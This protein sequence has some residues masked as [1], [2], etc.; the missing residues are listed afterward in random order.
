MSKI[1]AV[2]NFGSGYLIERRVLNATSGIAV[3]LRVWREQL[4]ESD[5]A[6]QT[7]PD[8]WTSQCVLWRRGSW[9]CV[10]RSLHNITWLF[11]RVHRTL[12][13]TN[14]QHKCS[15]IHSCATDIWEFSSI[16][17]IK[18]HCDFG[19]LQNKKYCCKWLM[20]QVHQV[21]I[22]CDSLPQVLPRV[23]AAST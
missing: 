4:P 12:D 7:I 1:H 5:R 8:F 14:Y 18:W 20:L 16:L 17:L 6:R 10:P 13:F 3:W 15:R 21:W 19:L 2:L 22:F 11:L 9:V 23:L